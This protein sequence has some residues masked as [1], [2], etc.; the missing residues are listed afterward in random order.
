MHCARA[1]LLV[2]TIATPS[3]LAVGCGDDDSGKTMS[4]N[5]ASGSDSSVPGDAGSTTRDAGSSGSIDASTAMRDAS[6]SIIDAAPVKPGS[7]DAASAA[8][9]GGAPPAP[10]ADYTKAENWLC[11]PDRPTD[12]C[13]VNLDTTIVRAD[14]TLEV[15]KFT[16]A[17]NPPIDCFYVYPTVSLDKT[18]NSDLVPGDEENAVVRAQ[19][20]RLASRCRLFAP[21]YRQV[22]L[23]SLR[24]L[25]AGTPTTPD[26]DLG[27]R[28]VLASWRW[29]LQNENKGR[30]VVLVG[31]SQGSGVLTQLIKE[32]IDPDPT[33]TP[34]LA[35]FLFGTNVTV[36]A[37]QVVGGSFQKVPLCK[38]SNELG[39]VVSYVSFRASSPP[40]SNSRFGRT[41]TAGQVVGCVN[42]AN[43]AGGPAPLHAYLSTLGAGASGATMGGWVTGNDPAK[44]VTTP[45]VSVPGLL[46]GECKSD[47]SGQYLAVTVNGNPADPRVDDIVGDVVT[48]G[49]IQADWGLHLIDVHMTMG[50]TLDLIEA[51]TKAFQ[52][53]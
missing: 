35:A 25:I 34:L 46:T 41:M 18:D 16:A 17:T 22:T 31:H 29:Y 45:F 1:L 10:A 37:G 5:N 27:Y 40:P 26:R 19:F 42:P 32:Q 47:A 8:A 36:P 52:A 49:Q 23:T 39:C 20:A 51:K 6:S 24:A 13:H 12:A 28:D 30:G 43:L 21:M 44:M 7:G 53:R 15:E 38:T 48:S 3:I 4:N 9:D 2:C 33:K 11:R 14:G 50:D